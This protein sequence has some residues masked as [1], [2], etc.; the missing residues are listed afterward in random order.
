MS[1]Y[2]IKIS[3]TLNGCCVRLTSN[4][5]NF[6]GTLIVKRNVLLQTHILMLFIR[7]KIIRKN[8]RR[9]NGI[10]SGNSEKMEGENVDTL[11]SYGMNF[12]AFILCRMEFPRLK[13]VLCGK[14]GII[15][16]NGMLQYKIQR[17]YNREVSS[18]SLVSMFLNICIIVKFYINNMSSL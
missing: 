3:S 15:I 18:H 16:C 4:H 11:T 1:S 8:S 13:C 5:W 12:N 7:F 10:I 9:E 14:I 17:S 2:P 6:I